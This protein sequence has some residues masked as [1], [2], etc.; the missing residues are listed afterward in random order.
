MEFEAYEIIVEILKDIKCRGDYFT[1]EPQGKGGHVV[2]SRYY[3][4]GAYQ[5][6]FRFHLSDNFR[7]ILDVNGL[8]RKIFNLTNPSSFDEIGSHIKSALSRMQIDREYHGSDGGICIRKNKK[9]I[10]VIE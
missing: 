9:W 10:K 4:G 6:I 3:S 7:I 8:Q 1:V 5:F 2:Y